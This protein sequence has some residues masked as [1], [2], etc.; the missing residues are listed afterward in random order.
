M[1]F[2]FKHIF[3]TLWNSVTG[4]CVIVRKSSKIQF[5]NYDW[6]AAV[7]FHS[8]SNSAMQVV[9]TTCGDDNDAPK[10]AH[11]IGDKAWHNP[12]AINCV[13][14]HA[15]HWNASR[16]W[17]M[18]SWLFNDVDSTVEGWEKFLKLLTKALK[19]SNRYFTQLKFSNLNKKGKQY[20]CQQ[21]CPAPCLAL[22]CQHWALRW[23]LH[24]QWQS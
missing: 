24:L 6:K 23:C 14:H 2:S 10:A 20:G 1:E 7:W 13:R 19:W 5:T 22:E 3:N 4:H 21:F 16:S 9:T 12:D 11:G 15:Q 8:W 18:C 17:P